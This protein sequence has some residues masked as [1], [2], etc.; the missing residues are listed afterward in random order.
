[1]PIS[2]KSSAALAKKTMEYDVDAIEEKAYEEEVM[3]TDSQLG[4]S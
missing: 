4:S 3:R 1:M 2:Q